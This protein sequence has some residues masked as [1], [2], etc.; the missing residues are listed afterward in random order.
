MKYTKALF[1]AVLAAGVL[2]SGCSM[3]LSEGALRPPKTTGREAEI[4]RLIEKTA[5]GSYTL[6]YPKTGQ[7]RSAIIT[8]DL[9]NDGRDEAVSFYRSSDEQSSTQ[10]LVMC[11]RDGQWTL[12]GSFTIDC[13]DVESIRFA[14]YNYDG[15]EEIFAGFVKNTSL[16]ELHIFE[17]SADKAEAKKVD[18][19]VTY[20]GYAIGDYDRDGS[21]E[22]ISLTTATSDTEAQAL[23]TDYDNKRL[24]TLSEC[25]LDSSVTRYERLVS[26]L[27]DGETMGVTADGA[28]EDG[29]NTQ[30]I[31]YDIK[32]RRLIDFPTGTGKGSDEDT[33]RAYAVFCEDINDDGFIEIPS[34]E[35][36]AAAKVEGIVAPVVTWRT[37]NTKKLKTRE[38]TRCVSNFD[39]GY[40]FTLP[41]NFIGSTVAILSDDKRSL[42]IYS[43]SDGQPDTLLITLKVFDISTP[44][45]KMSGYSALETYNQYIYTYKIDDDTI[46]YIDDETVK[47]NFIIHELNQKD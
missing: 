16:N 14:D 18:Y 27:I 43:I 45:D 38:K 30:V 4:Q 13:A 25:G 32:K 34:V 20:S 46:Y 15:V 33:S 41:E 23:L 29:Y 17:F 8:K 19:T 10:M 26:G 11:D 21:N 2:L 9:D 12:C 22:I 28:T 7:Y 31:F 40:S 24:Y 47:N 6:K 3:D 39:F 36:S 42:G 1:A 37:L 44:S 5:G 35:D